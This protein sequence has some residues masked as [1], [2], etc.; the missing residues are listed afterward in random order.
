MLLSHGNVALW[1]ALLAVLGAYLILR[2]GVLGHSIRYASEMAPGNGLQHLLLIGKTLGW[3]VLLLIWPFGQMS[4]VHPAPTPI[5]TGDLLAWLGLAG[6]LALAA[7]L[8][9]LLAR[10]PKYR[11][12]ALALVMALVALAPVSNLVPLTIGDNIVQD[13][14]LM[15]PLVFIVLALAML[16]AAHEGRRFIAIPAAAWAIACAITV[17]GL[18][19]N[20]ASNT[21]LWGQAYA[22]APHSRIAG[23][24]YVAALAAEYRDDE[25]ASVARAVLANYP[26]LAST[27]HNLAMVLIRAENYAESEVH[28]RRAI[29]LYANRDGKDRLD[30]SE[31]HNLLGLVLLNQGRRDEAEQALRQAI[32]LTPYLTRPH[33][34]LAKLLYERGDWEAGDRELDIALRYDTAAMAEYHRREGQEKKRRMQAK[35]GQG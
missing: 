13:R 5:A 12:P 34:N 32:S 9:Y 19:P 16:W 2:Q 7:M 1:A 8:L 18:L 11:R 28:A 24:N 3:Y 17:I 30:L 25:A 27:H 15:L 35:P 21:S 33:F 23:E 26:G 4:P 14:Y 29:K 6:V 22:K 31:A 10:R 20:W